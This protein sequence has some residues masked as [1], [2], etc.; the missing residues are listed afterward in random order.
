MLVA[1]IKSRPVYSGLN[2]D[3]NARRHLFA[4]EAGLHQVGLQERGLHERGHRPRGRRARR[5]PLH[6]AGGLHHWRDRP[7]ARAR[8]DR[9]QAG[10]VERTEAEGVFGS[11]IDLDKVKIEMTPYDLTK[12][13]ITYRFR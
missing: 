8:D 9:Q 13:R 4:L 11:A 12:G 2:I 7:A 3:P 5:E 10:P 6:L 1:G